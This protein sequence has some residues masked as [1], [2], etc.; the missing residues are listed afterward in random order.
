[1]GWFV[2][3][4]L[5][6][7]LHQGQ[8]FSLPPVSEEIMILFYLEWD[9]IFYLSLIIYSS[10]H[11]LP[12]HPWLRPPPSSRHLAAAGAASTMATLYRSVTSAGR[13]TNQNHLISP[14]SLSPCQIEFEVFH[15]LFHL[16]A[17]PGTT[18][19]YLEPSRLTTWWRSVTS[20]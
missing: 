15:L 14:Q 9:C 16:S 17:F 7:T 13:E 10:R 1:M 19:N 2:L 18:W 8:T 20:A 3:D 6:P 5:G 11:L 4:C 12:F